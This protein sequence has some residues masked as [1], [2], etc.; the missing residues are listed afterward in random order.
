MVIKTVYRYLLIT[1]G[2][3]FVGLGIIGIFLPVMPTTIF[4]ILA[5]WCFAR[6]S[7]KFYNRLLSDKYFGK[8]IKDYR[9]GK[10]MPVRAKIISISMLILSICYS[11][12]FAVDSIYIKTFLVIVGISVSVYILSIKTYRQQSFIADK[13]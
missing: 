7:E 3:I 4:L 12:F 5:A 10:G 11:I 6:S 1:A 13:E 2:F 9:E 8:L